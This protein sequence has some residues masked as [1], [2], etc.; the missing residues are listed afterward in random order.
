MIKKANRI[1]LLTIFSLIIM[2]NFI[3]ARLVLEGTLAVELNADFEEE[4][5]FDGRNFITHGIYSTDFTKIGIAIKSDDTTNNIRAYFPYLLTASSIDNNEY[6]IVGSVTP[7][8]WWQSY[9]GSN[10]YFVAKGDPFAIGLSNR[11]I[12][13]DQDYSFFGFADTLGAFMA[14]NSDYPMITIKL[15]GSYLNAKVEAYKIYDSRVS[16]LPINE[17]LPSEVATLELKPNAAISTYSFIEELADYTLLKFSRPF[18]KADFSF[19]YGE[20]RLDN[21]GFFENT[22]NGSPDYYKPDATRRLGLI[23]TNYGVDFFRK[24]NSGLKVQGEYLVSQGQWREYNGTHIV[25]D[26]NMPYWNI[27]GKIGGTAGMLA[28]EGI[29]VG[30]AEM[31]VLCATVEPDF[32]LVAPR[33]PD[34]SYNI[35]NKTLGNIDTPFLLRTIYDPKRRY[36]RTTEGSLI[37]ELLG[38]RTFKY[39]FQLP[40]MIA[41]LPSTFNLEANEYR[42]VNGIP[43]HY[44]VDFETGEYI[45][46]DHRQF[47]TEL[48]IKLNKNSRLLVIGKVRKYFADNNFLEQVGLSWEKSGGHINNSL[49]LEKYSRLRNFQWSEAEPDFAP[50]CQGDLTNLSWKLDGKLAKGI[51]FNAKVDLRKGTYEKD[52]TLETEDRVL[53]SPYGLIISNLFVEKDFDWATRNGLVNLILATEIIN[54]SGDAKETLLEDHLGLGIVGYLG[55]NYPLFKNVNQQMVFISV[56][57]PEKEKYPRKYIKNIFHQELSYDSQLSGCNVKIGYSLR[58][59]EN[60]MRKNV[61]GQIS[62]KVGSAN[63]SI[64]YGLGTLREATEVEYILPGQWRYK[65]PYFSPEIVGKP[66]ENWGDSNIAFGND[67]TVGQLNMRFWYSF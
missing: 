36:E 19:L 11:R 10:Y 40:G 32:Q 9:F 42:Q 21:P 67:K 14:P 38:I 28:F 16:F 50:I 37:S 59:F 54:L 13:E 18:G 39:T 66:W 24:W 31:T 29:K 26:R 6:L 8:N 23:K 63:W 46:K 44:E 56:K 45:I 15:T 27:L 30:A 25:D 60:E 33:H 58:P 53:G 51:T 62:G 20:K 12:F 1:V 4:N 52:L 48:C 5:P 41:G 2:Q 61:Y 55:L 34:Y 47:D 64:T 35:Y 43:K 65:N 7:E 22:E 17:R 49:T 57:G 3:M